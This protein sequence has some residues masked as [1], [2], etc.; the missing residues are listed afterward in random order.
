MIKRTLAALVFASLS[1]TALAA[2]DTTATSLFTDAEKQEIGKVAMEYLV[3]NPEVLIAASNELKAREQ[4]RMNQM[5]VEQAVKL[6]AALLENETTP[7]EGSKDAKVAIIKFLDYQCSYCI[8]ASPVVESV[9]EANSDAKLLVKN[10][11]VLAKRS[12]LSNTAAQ[13][14]LEVFKQQGEEGFTAFHHSMME[15]AQQGNP[16]TE[17]VLLN[18]ASEAGVDMKI[19]DLSAWSDELTKSVNLAQQLGFSGTPAYVVM[20]TSGASIDNVT[21]LGGYV[22]AD[23]LQQAV[24]LAQQ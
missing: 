3:N 12:P 2:N 6:E 9:L 15:S 11:P 5:Q 19:E 4:A 16:L 18:L 1:T 8:K 24:E 7:F 21:V 23:K 10:F 14:S 13:A 20:P 17:E 22:E